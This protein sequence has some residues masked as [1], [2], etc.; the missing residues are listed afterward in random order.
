[1]LNSDNLISYHYSKG[2]D[3]LTRPRIDVSFSFTNS[4]VKVMT[5]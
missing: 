3:V 4:S 1:M 5:N 2:V